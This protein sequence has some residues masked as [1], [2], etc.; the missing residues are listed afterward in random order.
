M[1]NSGSAHNFAAAAT[2]MTTLQTQI[3]VENAIAIFRNEYTGRDIGEITVR[4]LRSRYIVTAR[5]DGTLERLQL[6]QS[7]VALYSSDNSDKSI[8]TERTNCTGDT[9]DSFANHLLDNDFHAL[10]LIHI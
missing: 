1:I 7:I 10:S 8:S 9:T 2:L 4:T 6:P 5:V 3:E